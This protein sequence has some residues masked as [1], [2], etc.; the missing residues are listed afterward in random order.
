MFRENT[1]ATLKVDIQGKAALV[2][3]SINL[4]VWM[5]GKNDHVASSTLTKLLFGKRGF[6]Q[7]RAKL[8]C[9]S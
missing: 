5:L 4:P 7:A 6:R 8:R 9:C 3:Q 2:V 1:I